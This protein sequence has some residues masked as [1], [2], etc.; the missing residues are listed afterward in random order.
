MATFY[1]LG[2]DNIMVEVD[3]E[4]IPILDGSASPFVFLIKSAG[5]E[6]Q[7]SRKKFIKF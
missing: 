1:G 3:N 7:S 4:E 5:I 2:I 6:L